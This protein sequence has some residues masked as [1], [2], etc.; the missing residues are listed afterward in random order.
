MAG[1]Q[2]VQC[3][4]MSVSHSR[5]GAS[6]VKARFTRSSWTGGPCLPD[7]PLPRRFTIAETMPFSEQIRHTRRSDASKPRSASSSAISRYPNVG[8]SSW[9]ST[10]ALISC[11][12]SQSRSETGSRSHR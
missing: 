4:V 6:A 11:A 2:A 1:I 5:F 8:A 9:A 7:F 10:A 12:S 3:S